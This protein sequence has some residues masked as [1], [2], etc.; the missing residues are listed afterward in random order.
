MREF[1]FLDRAIFEF[2]SFLRVLNP[3]SVHESKPSPADQH[4][5]SVFTETQRRH[6]AGLMRVN[7]AG[8]VAAQA[9]YR[10]QALT[11]N[12]FHVKQAMEQA[13][14]EELQHL[15]WCQQRLDQVASKSSYFNFL[16]YI[17]S[18]LLGALAG[19]VG[20]SWSLGFLVETEAQVSV[21][22]LNHLQELPLNDFKSRA[23]LEK[24]HEDETRHEQAA[25]A[26]GAINLPES[27]KRVMRM[28]SKL[29][30]KTSYYF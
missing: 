19:L 8:E 27:I 23:I 3:G 17:F 7:H 14:D 11:A 2:D 26:A 18:W 25:R 6:V 1:T 24:M 30:T 29:L 5:E 15:Y 28:T 10:G 21:H 16:W 4:N 22:L 20:D 13:A 9:L 12:L